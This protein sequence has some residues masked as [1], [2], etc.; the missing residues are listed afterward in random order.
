M[1]AVTIAIDPESLTALAC[2]D[3]Q[4]DE[5]GAAETKCLQALDADRQ[6][7]GAWTVLG[8]IL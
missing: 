3:L 4:R 7:A 1:V 8:M 6:H 2:Q 5:L